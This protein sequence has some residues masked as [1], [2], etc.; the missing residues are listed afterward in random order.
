M[1]M[2][3]SRLIRLL[4]T[5]REL[6]L[7]LAVAA[8]ALATLLFVKLASE[9]ADGDTLAWDR[10]I[11][12][13]LRESGTPADPIGPQWL[14]RVMQDVTA[15]GGGTVLTLVTILVAA[16]LLAARKAALALFVLATTASGGAVGSLLKTLFLRERPDVV[17]H[18]VEVQSLSFPSA[19]A[20]NSALIYL[21]LGAMLARSESDRAVRLYVVSAATFLALLIG[22]SRVYLGVHYPSDVLAG[23]CFGAGW[24]ALSSLVAQTLRL[25]SK[26]RQPAPSAPPADA[27]S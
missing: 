8:V 1:S 11:L 7:L 24:A 3:P 17:P 16:Y 14:L 22:V 2:H 23:W 6:E 26:P 5:R 13:A 4:R 19:H 25:R 9:M 15:L 20:L 10:A 21:T 18:L 27:S 12:R